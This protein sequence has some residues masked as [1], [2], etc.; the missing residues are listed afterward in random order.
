MTG[1]RSAFTNRRRLSLAVT[2][3]AGTLALALAACQPAGPQ[4]APPKT[5]APIPTEVIKATP[6]AETLPTSTPDEEANAAS[7]PTAA[8]EPNQVPPPK[9]TPEGTEA[10]ADPV[11]W[12]VTFGL[13]GGFAGMS[14][15]L[16]VSSTGELTARDDADTLDVTRQ[17]SS[18]ELAQIR[19]LL[20]A[21]CPFETAGRPGLCA[22]CFTYSL[23]VTMDGQRFV[24]LT[25]DVSLPESGLLS[26]V[27]TLRLTLDE[28]LSTEA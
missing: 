25:N 9:A 20:V 21:A 26:L 1:D 15:S 17:A 4:A 10:C 3:I 28:A 2:G 12:Q 18:D 22:D 27:E 8:D 19:G 7:S 6:R 11:S 5:T 23:D 24:A 14:R 16:T 13:S